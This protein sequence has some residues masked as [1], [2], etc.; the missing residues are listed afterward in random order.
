MRPFVLSGIQPDP[1]ARG[2]EARPRGDLMLATLFVLM[3][4]G[5]LLL[6]GSDATGHDATPSTWLKALAAPADASWDA[7]QDQAPPPVGA[8]S[9]SHWHHQ[10]ADTTR[11]EGP[12][13]GFSAAALLPLPR[14]EMRGIEPNVSPDLIA[15]L[16]RSPAL[17]LRHCVFLC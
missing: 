13:R 16:T 15:R 8:P 4:L 14:R 10:R 6:G 9:S 5:V 7:S 2:S 1:E 12:S 11:A 3:P 17:H